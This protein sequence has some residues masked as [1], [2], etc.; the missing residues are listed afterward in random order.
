MPF[1]ERNHPAEVPALD[2][3]PQRRPVRELAIAGV[4][5]GLDPAVVADQVVDAVKQ[6]RFFVLSHPDEARAAFEAQLR[7]LIEDEPPRLG[8][9]WADN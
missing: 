1:A 7:W 6:R 2:A 3:H 5:H 8:G 9:D 4:A